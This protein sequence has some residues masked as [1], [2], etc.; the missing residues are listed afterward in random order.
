MKYCCYC[1]GVTVVRI[2]EKDDRERFVCS[3]CEIVHY[4]NPNVVAGCIPVLDER[5]L[6][7]RRA[8]EPRSGL[9]TL[10]A[11]F[12][13]LGET[14]MEA[15][16]RETLEEANARVS[17]QNLYVV[18]NLPHVDQVYMMFRARLLDMDFFP[19]VESTEVRLFAEPEIPWASLA[20][21]T[22]EITLEYYFADRRDGRFPLRIGDVIKSGSEF[23]LRRGPS[24]TV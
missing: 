18:L 11:G 12:M 4:Q 23:E 5:V 14:T 7:C 19:G 22:I 20:F 16:V 3:V 8:I 21:R 15:A 17:L 1:G 2:P 13:E 10:P 6:L 9:W 24:E